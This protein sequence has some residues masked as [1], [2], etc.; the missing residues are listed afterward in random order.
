[1]EEVWKW[2][3]GYEGLYELSSLG[4]I[5][6]NGKIL[7]CHKNKKTG[8][9]YVCLSKNGICKFKTVH[10]LL[11]ET[12]IPNIENKPCVDHIDGSRDNNSI[13]NL[14]WCTAKENCNYPIAKIRFSESHKGNIPSEETKL[15]RFESWVRNGRPMKRP[16]NNGR[17]KQIEQ[18]DIVSEEVI[19]IFPSMQEIKRQLGFSPSNICHCCKGKKRSVYGYLWKYHN[20]I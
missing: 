20:K 18:I 5:R 7:K 9:M 10:R 16:L 15:K 3:T 2:A 4:R 12:F 17:S 13:D 11:A 1:M 19:Q 14:R 8:Y 6:R